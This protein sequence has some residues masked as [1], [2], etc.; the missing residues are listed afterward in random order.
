MPNDLLQVGVVAD[1]LGGPSAGD[2]ERDILIRL[3]VLEGQIRVPTVARLFGVGVVTG[4]EVVHHEMELLL[5]RR[6]NLHLV[7]LLLQTLVG[8]ED[9]ERL[10]RVAGDHQDFWR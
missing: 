4:L 10:R 3:H 7:A 8:I 9:F 2:D 6:G 1:V 5:T